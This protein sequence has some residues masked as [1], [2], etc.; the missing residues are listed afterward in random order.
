[1]IRFVSDKPK[2]EPS[3]LYYF[4]VGNLYWEQINAHKE[5]KLKKG[6]SVSQLKDFEVP[7]PLLPIQQEIAVILSAVDERIEKEENE[8]NALD[9]LF[10][11]MLDALMRAKLRVNDLDITT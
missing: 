2:V 6:V 7:L 9:S 10:Q 5:G 1:M 11:S 8:K 4:T 3:Y